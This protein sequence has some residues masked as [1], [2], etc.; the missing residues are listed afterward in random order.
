MSGRDVR[1]Y[2]ISCRMVGLSGTVKV[3]EAAAASQ[4]ST[5][6]V[7]H[8]QHPSEPP[9]PS[10]RTAKGLVALKPQLLLSCWLTWE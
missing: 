8:V 1:R 5:W 10:Q 6:Y 3:Q 4:R 2:S 9:P 7:H